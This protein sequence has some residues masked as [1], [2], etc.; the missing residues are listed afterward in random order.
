M[1]DVAVCDDIEVIRDDVKKSLSSYS[2]TNELDYTLDEYVSGEDLLASGKEYDLVFMDYKFSDGNMNGILISRILRKEG[3]HATIIFLTCYPEMVFESFK[4]GT[5]RFLVKPLDENDFKETMDSF[6][7]SEGESHILKVSVEGTNHF[8][9]ESRILYIMG[10]GKYCII[11]FAVEDDICCHETMGMIGERLSE[12][13][14]YRCY[15][16]FIVNLSHVVGYDHR[17]IYL[18]NEEKI[19]L[20]R[21]KYRQ[22]ME[23]YSEYLAEQ[24]W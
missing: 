21:N 22:F 6:L 13:L 15:K 9:N 20:S 14:F 12:K 10:D 4:V 23:I 7:A 3:S 11:H 8:I 1:I 24:R 2:M 18:D 17:K 16:S 19:L 5:F